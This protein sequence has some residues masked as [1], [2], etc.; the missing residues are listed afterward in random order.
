[1]S[2]SYETAVYVEDVEVLTAALVAAIRKGT[3]HV[4]ERHVRNAIVGAS[5][6]TAAQALDGLLLEDLGAPLWKRGGVTSMIR[7]IVGKWT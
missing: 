4:P 3:E 6:I 7:H 1:M 2:V 5:L